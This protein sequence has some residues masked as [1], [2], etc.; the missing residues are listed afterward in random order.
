MN[1]IFE[2][3]IEIKVKYTE[4]LINKTEA[5]GSILQLVAIEIIA[6]SIDMSKKIDQENTTEM[7]LD[8]IVKIIE[9]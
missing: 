8:R 7:K 2:S 1:D 6:N 4:G 5:L 3:I 9:E